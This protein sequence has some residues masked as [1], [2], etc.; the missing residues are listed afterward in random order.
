MGMPKAQHARRYRHL[1]PFLRALREE[2]GFTQRELA[3]KLGRDH[4]FIHKSEIGERRVDVTE[5]MDWCMACG[6]NPEKAFRRL[7]RIRRS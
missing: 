5:F 4:V 2:A 7:R 1:P 3:S 6:T